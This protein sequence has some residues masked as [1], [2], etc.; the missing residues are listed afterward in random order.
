[1]AFWLPVRLIHTNRALDVTEHRVTR[2]RGLLEGFLAKQRARRADSLIAEGFRAGRI[3]DIGCGSYPAFLMTTKFAERHGLDRLPLAGVQPRPGVRL[4]EHDIA[5]D[6]GLPF[7]DGFFDV[8]TMLAV[9]EHLETS[10]LSRLLLEVRR[11]LRPGG[12][13][14]MTTPTRWTE[15]LLK[16][17]ASLGLVSHEEVGEH[18]AQYSRR[19]VASLLLSAGFNRSH[20][21]HG[22]FELGMNLWAVAEKRV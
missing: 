6:T 5:N 13:Y 1:V 14:V 20:I 17:M 9:F 18:K 2:G 8:V 7:E 22:T 3:L 12:V 11:V 4:V 21:R 16:A 10:T 19:E 15:R